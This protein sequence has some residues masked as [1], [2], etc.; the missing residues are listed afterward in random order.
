MTLGENL[1]SGKTALVTG[2]GANIGRSIAIELARVGASVVAV[3][4]DAKALDELQRELEKEG[5]TLHKVVTDVADEQAIGQLVEHLDRAELS[6]D[7]LVNNVGIHTNVE[8]SLAGSFSNWHKTLDT[9]LIGPYY[10]TKIVVQKLIDREAHGNVIFV[11]SIHQWQVRGHP[12]YSASKAAVG[13]VVKELAHELA[14]FGIRVNGIAPGAVQ[15]DDQPL[16]APNNK[17]PLHGTKIPS[18]YIG[19][20]AVFLASEFFSEYTTGSVVTIDAGLLA[21][22]FFGSKLR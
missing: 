11:S 20:C 9:N 10:L 21:R 4:I 22:G 19:R 13:M 1:L 2:A 15:F 6:I 7:I 8:G 16:D 18:K 5:R 17:I 12:A 3:D 14:G